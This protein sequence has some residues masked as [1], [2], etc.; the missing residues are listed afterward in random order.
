MTATIDEKIAE[1]EATLREV[2]QC[3]AENRKE[4]A[5]VDE[6]VREVRESVRQMERRKSL[7]GK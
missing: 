2:Q 4:I 3:A 7:W 5:K 6:T 1:I